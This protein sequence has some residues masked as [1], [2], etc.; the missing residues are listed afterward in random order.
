MKQYFL[1]LKDNWVQIFVTIISIVILIIVCSYNLSGITNNQLSKPE[2]AT[3]EGSSSGRRIWSNP[4]F[5]PIKLPQYALIKTNLAS[6]SSMRAISAFYGVIFVI[7]F[8]LLAKIWFSPKIAWVTSAMLLSSGLFLNYTRLAT[9]DILVPLGLLGLMWSG[10]WIFQSK[11]TNIKIVSSMI[12]LASCI[13]IPGLI[14]FVGLIVLA[15]GKRITKILKKTNVT[16][17]VIASLLLVVLL[18]PLLRSLFLNP[19]LIIEWLALP[20]T[21]SIHDFIKNLIMVSASL[22][23]RSTFDPIYNLGRLPYLDILTIALLVLGVYAFLLRYSL[24]RTRMLIGALC[25]AWLL[26]ATQNEIRI[27]LLLPL[28]Y[29]MVAG[30]IMFILQQWYSVFPKNPIARMLAIIMVLAVVSISIFY[31]STRYFVA[32]SNNPITNKVFK[33]KVPPNLL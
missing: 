16:S 12:I 7:I 3:I 13:Y 4:L 25:I 6:V 33:Y 22:V 30:G 32:W 24:V 9:T 21:L 15:L 11:N 29:L 31:N 2:V 19:K 18:T 14:W 20:S 23:V 8:F 5:L 1:W 27:N 28:I 10:W 26:I 17:I